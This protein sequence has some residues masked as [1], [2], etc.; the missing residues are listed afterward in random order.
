MLII[1]KIICRLKECIQRRTWSEQVIRSCYFLLIT[2]LL[3]TYVSSKA[4]L[5]NGQLQKKLL[6]IHKFWRMHSFD[7]WRLLSGMVKVDLSL[8]LTNEALRHEGV[9][10]SGCIDIHFLDLGTSW[11]WVINFTPH[12]LYTLEKSPRYP[13][14]RRLRGPRPGMDDLEKRKFF[15]LPELKLRPLGYP[16]RSH[17]LYRLRYPVS[18]C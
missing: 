2:R 5:W 8:G 12:S 16:S 6:F 18:L 3:S 10:G 14:D 4:V 1:S 11:R 15:T 13:L 9:G 7:F 17:S